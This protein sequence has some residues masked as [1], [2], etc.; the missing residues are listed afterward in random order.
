MVSTRSLAVEPNSSLLLSALYLN[1]HHHHYY[2]GRGNWNNDFYRPWWKNGGGRGYDPFCSYHRWH[3]GRNRD[4]WANNYRRDFDRFQQDFNRPGSKVAHA[5]LITQADIRQRQQVGNVKL[6][7]VSKVD[8]DRSRQQIDQ[9]KDIRNARLEA[10][11][12]FKNFR[13]DGKVDF[14]A[15]KNGQLGQ[16]DRGPLE[17]ARDG[18]P[19]KAVVTGDPGKLAGVDR[20]VIRNGGRKLQ[21]GDAQQKPQGGSAAF[22]LPPVTR[23]TAKVPTGAGNATTGPRTIGNGQDNGPRQSRTLPSGTARNGSMNGM[24]LED[25][26]RQ[27]RGNGDPSTAGNSR[28]SALPGN[29]EALPNG[30]PVGDAGASG[31]VI[32][33]GR[34]L[35]PDRAGSGSNGVP[36]AFRS[37]G[38]VVRSEDLRRQLNLDGS[39]SFPQGQGR[40]M[41]GRARVEMP[42]NRLQTPGAISRPSEMQ[43]RSRN[44]QVPGGGPSV[45]PRTNQGG[46]PRMNQGGGQPTFRSL[47]SGGGSQS[48]R[49]TPSFSGNGNSG[50][51]V[52]SFRVPS[53]GGGGGGGGGHSMMRS[54]GGDG[55]GGA[56]LRSSSGGGGGGRGRGRD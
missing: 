4:D 9:F 31:D 17:Q 7:Q 56:T 21:I 52:R 39:P 15:L 11:K 38:G 44:L 51:E 27:L 18:K 14:E 13:P 48:R 33:G 28:R 40:T 5:N 6:Q 54:R 19:G 37:R 46:Q 12:Q 34:T 30:R 47:P 49:S 42:Q 24:K 41:E 2:F 50:G 45:Q 8:F 43:Y 36:E 35:T 3:D 32:R 29:I 10:E 25:L 55:G 20:D 22:K 53:G 26:Q 16:N 1:R 23:T